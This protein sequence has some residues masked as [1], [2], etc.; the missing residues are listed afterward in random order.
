MS[1]L[2]F[3]LMADRPPTPPLPPDVALAAILEPHEWA[4]T[5]GAPLISQYGRELGAF[6][7]HRKRYPSVP[8]IIPAVPIAAPPTVPSTPGI[9]SF[10]YLA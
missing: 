7:H 5:L 10:I 1:S 3:Y 6:L 2:R 9:S 8:L 4:A